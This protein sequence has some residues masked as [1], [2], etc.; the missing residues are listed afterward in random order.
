[1]LR[2]A[3]WSLPVRA[4]TA[5]RG[6]HAGRAVRAGR[7]R[8]TSA[9]ASAPARWPWT[10]GRPSWS[11]QALGIAHGPGRRCVTAGDRGLAS[12]RPR[13]GQ[14]GRRRLEPRR[15][16]GR[17]TPTS[18]GRALDAALALDDR[19]LVEDLVVGREIDVAV[20][21]P[22]RTARWLVGPPLEIVVDGLFDTARKYDG[23][24]DF[25]LP[26]RRSTTY[27]A[28]RWRTPRARCTTR[29]AAPASRGSTSSSP[30]RPGAQ[31]GEHD[32]RA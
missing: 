17:T 25:R 32:A 9:P 2:A 10:S 20:L 24:A 18:C 15:V 6:R 26:A 31:R 22:R 4:R 3:T 13:R 1:M 5:R 21:A 11:P 7:R 14:A 28:R 29:S 30:T 16:A 8:R 27:S 23:S 12:D 19:V